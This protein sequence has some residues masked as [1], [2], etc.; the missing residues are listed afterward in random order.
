MKIDN[1]KVNSSNISQ[2]IR[3]GRKLLT[4]MGLSLALTGCA[5]AKDSKNEL[6]NNSNE[7]LE[8]MLEDSKESTVV[9]IDDVNQL[10]LILYDNNCNPVIFDT[11]VNKMKEANINVLT[12]TPGEPILQNEMSTIITM[13]GG[14]YN[15]NT[16]VI[17]GSYNNN[18]HDNSDALALS[19]EASF[20]HH[21]LGMDGIR[22]GISEVTPD[23]THKVPTGTELS[24]APSSSFVVVAVG[25]QI[26]INQGDSVAD[27]VIEG[28]TRA[29]GVIKEATDT[30]FL[31]RATYQDLDVTTLASN[32]GTTVSSLIEMNEGISKHNTFKLQEDQIIL[33]PRIKEYGNFDSHQE[34]QLSSTLNNQINK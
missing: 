7:Q 21:N 19:M 32:I 8:A 17:L 28:V 14:I 3:N 29:A 11:T 4:I 12:A 1:L 26:D 31:Y 2:A 5:I 34:F 10:N 25:D 33:H 22:L 20:K 18:R 24:I 16:S 15:S 27:S 30:D 6:E 13:A 23:Y 9:S